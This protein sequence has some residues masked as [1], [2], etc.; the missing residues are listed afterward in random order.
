[1]IGSLINVV[2]PTETDRSEDLGRGFGE[3]GRIN[4]GQIACAVYRLV[5][6]S[7]Q[8]FLQLG[9]DLLERE[10]GDGLSRREVKQWCFH[11]SDSLHLR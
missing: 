7:G 5:G 9:H 10:A 3:V 2:P 6:R 1:V 8:W 11:V 4:I